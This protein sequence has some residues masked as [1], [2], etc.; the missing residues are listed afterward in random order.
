VNTGSR[1]R[2]TYGDTGLATERLRLVAEAFEPT[3]RSFL[4]R[5]TPAHP[6]AA[7]DLGC[8]PGHTTRLMGEVTRARHTVGL[9]R[10]DAFIA[11]AKKAALPNISFIRHDVTV[12]PFPT[13]P[14]EVAFCRLLLAHLA[15]PEGVVAG[16][17]KQ[18]TI[19][20]ML[21]LDELEAIDA[22]DSG[23]RTYLDEVAIPVVKSQ[24]ARLLAGPVL[25]VMPDPPL[26]ERVADNVVTLVPPSAL[27]ARI[28]AMNLSVLVNQGEIAPRPDLAAALAGISAGERSAPTE[29]RLRQIV[30]RRAV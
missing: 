15:D 11:T 22:P 14:A 7:L 24:G 30:F 17:S 12:I 18:L 10:S 5:A 19:D 2:Y 29:W 3:T 27:S 6:R 8:G 13:P 21:L 1:A 28:F 26:L 9:D 4:R 25:H 16:W 20:G 23:V